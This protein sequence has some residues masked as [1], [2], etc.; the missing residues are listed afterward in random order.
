MWK[1]LA[2]LGGLAVFI[3]SVLW[4][5]GSSGTST[6]AEPTTYAPD[7]ILPADYRNE[8]VHYAT[9]D[10]PDARSRDIYISPGAPETVANNSTARLP[11]GTIIVIEAHRLRNSGRDGLAD[12]IHVA[13][14]RADW[15]D[16]D[17]QTTE[18]AGDW[19]YFSFDPQTQQITDERMFDCFDC[20][21]NNSEIDFIFSRDE[22][23]DFGRT[24]TVQQ[25]FCNRP[26]RFPCAP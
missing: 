11:N 19:N 23:A 13:V 8:L 1:Y 17:Y 25:G 16:S 14:K 7:V 26:D 24:E 2:M 18:R 3:G 22:L 4:W 5:G 6:A 10:R 20:H 21:A 15:Q 9:I 12:N